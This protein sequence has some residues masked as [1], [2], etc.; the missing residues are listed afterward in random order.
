MRGFSKIAALKAGILLQFTLIGNRQ[1]PAAFGPA[2]GQYLAAI[3]SLHAFT[4][5]VNGFAPFPVRLKSPFHV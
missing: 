5:T 2:A 1:L 3:G 4:K